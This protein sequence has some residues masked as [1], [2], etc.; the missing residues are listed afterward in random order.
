VNETSKKQASGV[1]LKAKGRKDKRKRHRASGFRHQASGRND[2]NKQG[3]G[4][5]VTG[6]R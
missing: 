2:E 4:K 1:R 3:A 5:K 6:D